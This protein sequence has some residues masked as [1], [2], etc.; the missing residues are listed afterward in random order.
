MEFIKFFIFNS[1]LSN[2]MKSTDFVSLLQD[3]NNDDNVI[4]HLV[5]KTA[6]CIYSP[7]TKLV[8]ARYVNINFI[9]TA[10]D[11]PSLNNHIICIAFLLQYEVQHFHRISFKLNYYLVVSPFS[12]FIL[13][14]QSSCFPVLNS[15]SCLPPEKPCMGISSHLNPNSTL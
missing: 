14:S 6:F 2:T 7:A 5:G 12:E 11:R 8:S 1:V 3:C 13:S 10:A 15:I 4:S 9:I